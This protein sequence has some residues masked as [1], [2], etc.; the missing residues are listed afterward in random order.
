MSARIKRFCFR[1][2][3]FHGAGLTILVLC[4]SPA[5]AARA[6]ETVDLFIL[7]GQSNA[8]GVADHNG[9]A[10]RPAEPLSGPLPD[11]RIK[12][13]HSSGGINTPRE[14]SLFWGRLDTLSQGDYGPEFGLGRELDA[15]GHNTAIIKVAWG[16]T[17][18][19]NHWNS[20]TNGQLWQQ[21][22]QATTSAI[23]A[24]QANGIQVRARGFFW[25]QGESD[26]LNQ[27]F[28]E[29]YEINFSHLIEDVDLH[30][31]GLGV[32]V[33]EMRYVTGLIDGTSGNFGGTFP[34][35]DEVI[36]AQRG[37][38]NSMGPRGRW[39]STDLFETYDE[40]PWLGIND[41]LHFTGTGSTQ[42]GTAFAQAWASP[43]P[44]PTFPLV[45]GIVLGWMANRRG[46]RTGR[47]G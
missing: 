30:L 19:G 41:A 46:R 37:V 27:S 11:P 3:L 28:A 10:S 32:A 29:G 20:R 14:D 39:I 23:N 43:V 26:A 38:M 2:F 1:G 47:R 35:N 17:S 44:E 13:W 22:Q 24:L 40:A 36:A 33:D 7:A 8:T 45:G 5:P 15:Q 16:G 9:T 18:L 21:W 25:M 4:G 12:Y 31:T 34:W 42:L 6:Q